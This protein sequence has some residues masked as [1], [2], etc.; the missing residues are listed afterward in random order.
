[1][2]NGLWTMDD[3]PPLGGPGKRRV[4]GLLEAGEQLLASAG[5]FQVF[6]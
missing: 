1:M 4:R 6:A 5:D 2:D 3:G